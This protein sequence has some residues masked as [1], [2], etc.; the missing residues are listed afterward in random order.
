MAQS[1]RIIP[2]EGRVPKSAVLRAYVVVFFSTAAVAPIAAWAYARSRE[3]DNPDTHAHGLVCDYL[4]H[5]IRLGA[6]LD[7]L[8]GRLP[9]GRKLLDSMW[10]LIEQACL[11]VGYTVGVLN[12]GRY[13]DRVPGTLASYD[14]ALNRATLIGHPIGL[15]IAHR[16]MARAESDRSGREDFIKEHLH[17]ALEYASVAGSPS[18]ELKIKLAQVQCG[19]IEPLATEEVEALLDTTR[20]C[21][22]LEAQRHKVVEA[23]SRPGK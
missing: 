6:L 3:D 20:G 15:A 4:E 11:S 9:G 2:R 22:A 12:V 1:L 23:L 16:D 19:L 21:A 7:H 8:R 13:R 14:S 18:L 5:W 17:Q 10:R